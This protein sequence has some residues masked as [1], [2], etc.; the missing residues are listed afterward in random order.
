MSAQGSPKPEPVCLVPR[1]IAIH[2]QASLNKWLHELRLLRDIQPEISVNQ[3]GPF[4]CVN[5]SY[6]MDNC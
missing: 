1:A 2:Q 3:S 5:T 4:Y 6:P